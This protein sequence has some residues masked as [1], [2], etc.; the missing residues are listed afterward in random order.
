YY[1]ISIIHYYIHRNPNIYNTLLKN[2]ASD[3]C[4]YHI[5][6]SVYL[7]WMK[8]VRLLILFSQRNFSSN[9]FFAFNL[10]LFSSSSSSLI[11]F[12]ASTICE[13]EPFS[14]AIPTSLSFIKALVNPPRLVTTGTPLPIPSITFPGR[15]LRKTSVSF[16]RDN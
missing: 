5:V 1:I 4:T 3:N 9:S 2:K 7:F 13:E 6:R 12:M 14:T 8:L 10:N 11:C 16:K 15:T